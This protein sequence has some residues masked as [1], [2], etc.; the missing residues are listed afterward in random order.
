MKFESITK[1]IVC[2]TEKVIKPN[3]TLNINQKKLFCD[4]YVFIFFIKFKVGDQTRNIRQQMTNIIKSIYENVRINKKWRLQ[5]K[6]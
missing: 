6:K 2:R 4:L 1:N 5:S 3:V